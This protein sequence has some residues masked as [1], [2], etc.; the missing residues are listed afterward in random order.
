MCWYVYIAT[1][2]PLKDVIFTENLP[3]TGEQPPPLHFQAVGEWEKETYGSLFKQPYL[4]Y[5]GSD[6]GCSC[7]LKGHY[8]LLYYPDG[9]IEKE[10]QEDDPSPVA[11]LEFL[12][13]YTQQEPLEMYVVYETERELMPLQTVEIHLQNYSNKYIVLETRQFYAIHGE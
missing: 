13:S 10:W 2:E 5:V 11:F 9:R 8:T 4:Y 3:Q 7:G 6:T 1:S 12:T